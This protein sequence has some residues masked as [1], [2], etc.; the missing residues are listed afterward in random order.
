MPSSK[1]NMIYNWKK[2]G[3]ICD[4]YNALY[5]TYI[6]TMECETLS[7]RILQKNNWRC[8]DHNHETGLF[9]K[10]RLSSV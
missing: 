3:L 9:R 1:Y 10:I 2:S 5:E 4:D 6:G 8:L 7:N